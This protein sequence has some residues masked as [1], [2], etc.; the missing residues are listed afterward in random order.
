MSLAAVSIDPVDIASCTIE[1][2]EAKLQYLM[3]EKTGSLK[4]A[5]LLGA[6]AAAVEEIIRSKL[7]SH[8]LYNLQYRPGYQFAG[9]NLL[10]QFDA[11]DSGEPIRMTAAFAYECARRAIRLVTM[12]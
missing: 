1:L 10:L 7:R 9:F 4:R 2:D 6:A 11:I 5:G 3:R 8:Y 12:Y